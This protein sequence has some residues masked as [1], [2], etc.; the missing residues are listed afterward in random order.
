MTFAITTLV[1]NTIATGVLPVI[2]EHGLS[3]LIDTGN[4]KILFGV[5]QGL[6]I[7]SNADAMDIDLSEIDTVVL[8]HGH[9]DHARGIKKFLE[10]CGPANWEKENSCN[11]RR[12][13]P[14][15][16]RSWQIKKDFYIST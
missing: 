16:R 1:E 7:L 8:S 2:A 13:S 10:P 11:Y 6:A 14:F 3:F 5:G 4:R 15:F 12:A 9:F